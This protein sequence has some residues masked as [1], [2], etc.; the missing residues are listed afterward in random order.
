MGGVEVE[1]R[2]RSWSETKLP[3][4]GERTTPL[5]RMRPSWTGVMEIEEAPTSMTRAEAL[6]AAKLERCNQS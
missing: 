1:K 2:R 6:P 3:A 4:R 5:R